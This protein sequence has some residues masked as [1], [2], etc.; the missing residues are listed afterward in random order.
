MKESDLSKKQAA[1]I[2]SRGGWA[3]KIAGGPSQAGLPDVIGCYR[4]YFLGIET[5]MPGKQGTLTVLQQKTLDAM[6][7]AGG[8][9]VVAT[10]VGQVSRILDAIDR[11]YDG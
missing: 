8:I 11:A 2:R 10:T 7:A 3:R 4:K 1:L 5:K 6:H 9:T